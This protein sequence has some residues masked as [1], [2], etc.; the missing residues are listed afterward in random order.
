MTEFNT[1]TRGTPAAKRVEVVRAQWATAAL[2]MIVPKIGSLKIEASIRSWKVGDSPWS[3]YRSKV[4][5]TKR[6]IIIQS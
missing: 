6:I 3:L 5:A 2:R 1:S 4:E